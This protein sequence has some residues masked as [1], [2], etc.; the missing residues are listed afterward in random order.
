MPNFN[1][2]GFAIT[3]IKV[4]QFAT[5]DEAYRKTGELEIQTDAAFGVAKDKK[6]IVVKLKFR[7]YK[8]ESPFI[9]LETACYF[10]IN[11]KGWKQLE[12]E[13]N[14]IHIPK[15]L[16]AHLTV[17]TVG[18]TR[19]ILHCKTEGTDYNKYILPTINVNQLIE[20]D[21]IFTANE[22]A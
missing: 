15:K 3:N 22:L 10:E 16:I 12:K 8:K 2:L 7:F 1:D 6:S 11:T 18:T 17:L 4:V 20:E 9:T 19:G 21:V 5:T 14:S 13:D